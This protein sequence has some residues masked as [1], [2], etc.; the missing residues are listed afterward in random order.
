MSE[1]INNKSQPES[2]R[3]EAE[4]YEFELTEEELA[5]IASTVEALSKFKLDET[6]FAEAATDDTELPE[7]AETEVPE[8]ERLEAEPIEVETAETE[9]A[10]ESTEAD[11]AQVG[12]PEDELPEIEMSE[13]ELTEEEL[14]ALEMTEEELLALEVTETDLAEDDQP[15]TEQPERTG[16]RLTTVQKWLA[17]I[18]AVLAICVLG[19]IGCRS[20][21]EEP[22]IPTVDNKKPPVFTEPNKSNPEESKEEI[23]YDD[24]LIPKMSGERKSD[25]YYTI[26]V[27]GRDTGG[28]GNT[29]TMLLASYDVTNRK[30]TVMSIPRDTMVN[31]SW[32][33]KKINTVYNSYGKG[34]K[35]LEA[36]Y[37]EI[38]QLVGFEP[39]F[40]VVVEWEAVGA[41]VDAIGGVW[42]DVPY[43]MDYHD[44]YQNLIIEQEKGYRLLNGED[45]MQV[46]RWRKNDP[47]SPHGYHG[48]IGDSG[49]MKMQQN[50]LKAV[51]V[52]LLKPE[53]VTRISE[54][55]EVF[56]NN[57]QTSL[58]FKNILWFGLQAVQ[59]GLGV[60]DVTFVTMPY[61]Y[62]DVYSRNLTER[63]GTYSTLAYVVPKAEELLKL[64]N[65]SLNP[66]KEAFTLE[67]LDIMYVNPDGSI[68]ST[69]GQVADKEAALPPPKP[70]EP[71]KSEPASAP[72]EAPKNSSVLPV[73]PDA[74]V[75]TETTAGSNP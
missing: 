62:A 9:V 51:I 41:M 19:I 45:A 44:P 5:E 29:D 47:E 42:F 14:L 23:V 43:T 65:E 60:E 61:S 7:L 66:Y 48:G 57:V 58:S 56:E 71:E 55:A 49:R 35:G 70:P 64:V 53:N 72:A 1:E 24:G 21:F 59:G 37:K 11:L 31:V 3:S 25:K 28:G 30:A 33:G 17:A 52:Q 6:D 26:L 27:L 20:I 39:D 50:F 10:A 34:N 15:D 8:P 40:E 32:D 68:G 16:W 46:I 69:T 67:D 73:E 75:K 18:C 54:I 12:Q 2:E 13:L 63:L 22:E 38:S 4:V 36:V 74:A